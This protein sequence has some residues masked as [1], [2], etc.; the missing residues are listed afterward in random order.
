[1]YFMSLLFSAADG[2]K[3]K[4]RGKRDKSE[5]NGRTTLCPNLDWNERGGALLLTPLRGID[6]EVYALAQGNLVVGGLGAVGNDG[7]QITLNIP[8]AGRIPNGA[9]VERSVASPFTKGDH[10]VFNLNQ[11]DFTTARRMAKAINQLIL[12]ISFVLLYN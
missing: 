9:I 3:K 8:T 10:L 6:G 1:M 4:E 12:L 2:R 5:Q 7:S 11:S